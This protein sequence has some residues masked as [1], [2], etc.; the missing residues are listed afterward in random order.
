MSDNTMHQIK[1]IFA[2]E[3][4]LLNNVL[5][6]HSKPFSASPFHPLEEMAEEKLPK[7]SLSFSTLELPCVPFPAASLAVERCCCD[8]FFLFSLVF[9][10]FF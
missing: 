3:T 9:V 7:V 5:F 2:E 6:F 8:H 4:A 1:D 10:F